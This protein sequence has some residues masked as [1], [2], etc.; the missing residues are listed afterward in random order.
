M[1]P[2]RCLDDSKNIIAALLLDVH[3]THGAVFN[4]SSFLRTLKKVCKR[5][6]TEGEGFLTKTLPKLA[7]AF[8]KALAGQMPLKAS[9]Y[10]FASMSQ[11]ELPKFLGEF[12]SRVLDPTGAVLPDPCVTS[13]GVIRDVCYLFYKY[14][15]PYS[16]ELAQEV[17]SKFERTELDL[18]TSDANI[19]A[20]RVRI[21]SRF[22]KDS[23]LSPP[24]LAARRARKLLKRVFASFDPTDIKPRHGPGA[25]ATKQK[26]WNKYRWSN[27]SSRITEVYPRDEFF[28]V[29]LTH[30]CD[31][32]RSLT[33]IGDLSHPARVCLVP[34][35]SRGPRLISCEPVDFQ[36]IQQGLGSALVSWLE[37]HHLTRWTVHFTDQRPNQ[38]GALLGS[39]TGSYATLDLNEASDRVSLELVRLLFPDHL[40]RCLEA[41]RT[42]S[43]KLPDGRVIELRKFAPMGSSLCFPIL[44]TTIWALLAA[45]IHNAELFE[46]RETYDGFLVYGDDVVV[47]TARA[48]SAI[49]LLESFGL[50]VNRDKSCT[51]G[52]FRESCGTDAFN[53]ICVTPVRLRTVW[54]TSPSP[55]VYTSWISYANSMY[56]RQYHNVYDLI[57]GDLCRVYGRIPDDD[58]FLK[59]CPSLRWVPE[60]YRVR[61]YRINRSLQKKE[62]KVRDVVPRRSDHEIDGWSMLLRYFAEGGRPTYA[63]GRTKWHREDSDP[64]DH[65]SVRSYTHRRASKL[66]WRWR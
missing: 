19:A 23:D 53:G 48:D 40:V 50:K 42:T 49:E 4:Y 62:W 18:I 55:E 24:E 22:I 28:Y 46:G 13:I 29:S 10:G 63:F 14:E 6:S 65:F 36:W 38:L 33:T 37:Q 1:E 15:R 2:H 31:C 30:V 47:E 66:A 39:L 9:D 56:D 60:E 41:C 43:T 16:E 64:S 7:K 25:V 17:V 54:S 12:F 27:I 5:L 51:K 61:R 45:G 21:L 57:V 34:K 3:K 35:D 26:L 59:L 44:A 52:L 8:D 20:M 58:R 11:S 32:L